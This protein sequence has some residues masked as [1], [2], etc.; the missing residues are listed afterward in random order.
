VN[1]FGDCLRASHTAHDWPGWET[2]YRRAFPSFA[3]MV[4]H[5]AD[6]YWQRL[7]IDRTVVL[8][9]S[10]TLRIDEKVRGRN[11]VSGKVYNDILLEYLSDEAGD[12]PGWINKPILADYIAYAILPLG[13]CHLLPVEQ[14]QTAWERNG[15][16]WRR[17]Y[18]PIRA[19]NPGWVTCSVGVPPSVLYPAIGGCLRVSFEPIEAES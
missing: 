6:G 10:K 13:V 8:K 9:S 7:G 11:R 4:D 17:C 16:L 1:F 3:S 18:R 12:A 14:L 19:E 5:R 2:I 15:E